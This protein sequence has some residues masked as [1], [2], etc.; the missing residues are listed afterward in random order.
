MPRRAP[1]DV[2][3][4]GWHFKA[5][6]ALRQAGRR[7][8]SAVSSAELY[9]VPAH[10]P[11]ADLIVVPDSNSAEDVLAGLAR[12]GLAP[13]D[14]AAIHTMREFALVTA[15]LLAAH[16]DTRG[17]PVDTAVALRDK[18]VQKRLVRDAGLPT[19]ACHVVDRLDDLLGDTPPLPFVVKPLAGAG[20]YNTHAVRTRAQ[21]EALTAE[22][23]GLQGPWLVEEFIDGREL[24]IDGIVREGDLTFLAVSRYLNNVIDIK[25]G[26]LVGSVT[27]H[28]RTEAACYQQA[29]SLTR[30]ALAA[31]RLRDGVFHLEA[32]QRDGELV[33]S[34]CAGRIGGGVV[35]D[36]LIHA[37]GTDLLAEWARTITGQPSSPTPEP[38]S[39]NH[40]WVHLQA[41]AGRPVRLPSL[42]ALESRPG[43]VAAGLDLKGSR[44]IPDPAVSSNQRVAWAVLAGDSEQHVARNAQSLA[45]WFHD[46]A[47]ATTADA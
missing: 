43:C 2:L 19:A 37:F 40:G 5:V 30:D 46:T 36:T 6:D 38:H 32:F 41:E 25:T 22:G 21:L 8:I 15:A 11:R 33:F 23:E 44:V 14:F 31:L 47:L 16:G 24:H 1:N 34:E 42:D 27:L 35:Q 17:L 26:G 10:V 45:A 4:V 3:M 20:T 29:R 18:Y 9:R 13:A 7:V 28:P 12:E 39:R